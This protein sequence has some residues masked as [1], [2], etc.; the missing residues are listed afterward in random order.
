MTSGDH[1]VS[2]TFNIAVLGA[3]LGW[4]NPDT[5]PE[6]NRLYALDQGK[7]PRWAKPHARVAEQALR[8]AGGHYEGDRYLIVRIGDRFLSDDAVEQAVRRVFAAFAVTGGSAPEPDSAPSGNAPSDG[9]A[10]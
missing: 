2:A 1:P 4:A 3:V 8:E 9:G 10:R 7:S 5:G 6:N